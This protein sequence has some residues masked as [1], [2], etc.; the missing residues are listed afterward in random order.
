M[1][2]TIGRIVY[3]R[4]SENDVAE[5]RRRRTTGTSI[6]E[7]MAEKTWPEGAQ[8]HIG[9]PVFVGQVA[10]A[11]ITAVWPHEYGDKSGING[12]AF[13]DGCDVLWILSVKEGPENGEWQWPQITK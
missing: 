1:E 11:I 4:L 12:Q 8:A 2:P 7:R 5:I 6:A 13:L 10:P 9:N 3:Y